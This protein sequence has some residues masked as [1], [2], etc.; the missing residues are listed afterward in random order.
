M[1]RVS[2]V[3]VDNSAG[4][5][6][7]TQRWDLSPLRIPSI[8]HVVAMNSTASE[9][10]KTNEALK[11]W[12]KLHP[13]WRIKLWKNVLDPD[14]ELFTL[15][16]SD[17]RVQNARALRF[18]LV[19]RF[20]GVAVDIDALKPLRSIEP[21]IR[22]VDAFFAYDVEDGSSVSDSIF[23]AI[24]HHPLIGHLA[25]EAANVGFDKERLGLTVRLQVR[26]FNF[27]IRMFES[28]L[29]YPFAISCFAGVE[30]DASA[31]AYA[32]P[33]DDSWTGWLL[34]WVAT[35]FSSQARLN[36]PS[37]VRRALAGS[38]SVSVS[39]SISLT[40]SQTPT[41]TRTRTQS[42]TRTGT[43]TGTQTPSPS[44]SI[45]V[46]LTPSQTF[47]PSSSS[48][49]SRTQSPSMT[50]S[51]LETVTTTPSNSQIRSAIASSSP[52]A[53]ATQSQSSEMPYT[54]LMSSSANAVTLRSLTISD[55]LPVSKLRL[56]L[57]RCP[58][59][60]EADVLSTASISCVVTNSASPP[61]VFVA[62][63]PIG[64]DALSATV[65]STALF[66]VAAP[67]VVG[68]DQL[69]QIAT[70]VFVGANFRPLQKSAVL[71]CSIW[72]AGVLPGVPNASSGLLA[73]ASIRL[74][75]LPS[76]WPLWDDAI[77]ISASGAMRSAR[78]GVV[79]NA[80]MALYSAADRASNRTDVMRAAD[81]SPTLVAAQASP[82]II[83]AAARDVWTGNE[84]SFNYSRLLDEAALASGRD[85]FS[86]VLSGVSRVVLFAGLT[87]QNI[88]FTFNATI[89]GVICNVS[90]ISEDGVW[91]LLDTPSA[92]A[93]CGASGVVGDCGYAALTLTSTPS[94]SVDALGVSLTC[95]TFCPG[96]VYGNAFP[97]AV[98][99]PSEGFS[100]GTAPQSLLG[101][102]PTLLPDIESD[103]S[104]EGIYYAA[105][106]SE[107]GLWT[108]PASGA[109]TNATDP[110]S[111]NCALGSGA[112][113]SACPSGALCPGG[114]RLWPRIGFWAP[115]EVS[116]AVS[117]CGPPDP[118]IK[119]G[120]WNI[121]RAT[122]QCGLAY[123]FGSPLCGAC[124]PGFY[125]PGD[126]SCI[127]CPVVAGVWNR[128]QGIVK[129]LGG[130][131][132]SALCVGLVLVALVRLFGGTLNGSAVLLAGLVQWSVAALQTVAQAAP[133]SAAALPPFL[134]TVFRGLAVLQLDGVLLPPACTGAYAF[135][136]QVSLSFK[137]LRELCDRS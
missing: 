133:A 30:P 66:A 109:C 56:W 80:T 85:A 26:D 120:G 17:N 32:V 31:L 113:C 132:V 99:V 135:E 23:G 36:G 128:Y 16:N 35:V 53:S 116:D 58:A 67:C 20:G 60:N 87:G 103:V 100:L 1:S 74:V 92:A 47:T 28:H 122:V 15:Y 104:S 65:T 63:G 29:F 7:R 91:A 50:P 81:V 18:E 40:Q 5:N 130:V 6:S 127:A 2:L 43:R 115:N 114:S 4:R 97:I 123:R 8:I 39:P 88:P 129:L 117:A 42:G 95:P 126:G 98:T 37:Y 119:C 75:V 68:S 125:L 118:D 131:L 82:T 121:S 10:V 106:C 44:E 78:L 101:A 25:I 34:H 27:P 96:T 77:V 71:E 64:T 46:T 55:S 51:Q 136:S 83:L 76:Q 3:S 86:L 110:A 61:S 79:I 33:N 102:L 93:L 9:S 73:L 94:L 45:S 72:A 111:R 21:L 41:H 112:G 90:A 108:D 12:T 69:V 48:T 124:A 49:A 89:G 13:D 59:S 52:S 84:A 19:W 137:L 134:A 54:L 62:L 24:P 105:A 14:S 38:G 107:T 22:G 70:A 57:N 11:T